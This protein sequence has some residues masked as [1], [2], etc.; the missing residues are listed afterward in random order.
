MFV[1]KNAWRAITR[2][3]ARNVTF[4]IVCMAVT[5]STVVGLTVLQADEDTRTTIY[6]SQSAEAVISPR[7]GGKGQGKTA[8]PLGWEEY[9]KYAQFLQANSLQ[10]GVYYYESAPARFL[11]LKPA[12]TKA[13][14]QLVGLSDA[15]V[16]AKGPYGKIKRTQGKDPDY[17]GTSGDSAMISQSMAKANKLKPG[18]TIRLVDPKDASRTID[19][20]VSGVYEAKGSD[21]AANAV[22]TSFTTFAQHGFDRTTQP[23]DKGHEL[24]VVFQLQ[25]PA[26]LKQFTDAL[27]KAGLSEKQYKVTSPSLQAYQRSVQPLHDQAGKIKGLLIAI[28]VFG[29]I[30]ALVWL[31]FALMARGNE[32]G[33]AITIGVTKARIGWRLALE[34]LM[35]TLPGL[36]LGLVAGWFLCPPAIRSLISLPG[37]QQT[38]GGA[39]LW[40]AGG[41]GLLVCL[42]LAVAAWLHAGL[43]RTSRLYE[44]GAPKA[45]TDKN[46][47]AADADA[48]EN[49]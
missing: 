28:L 24:K 21:V 36:I 25:N 23:G 14:M 30:L 41:T 35:I 11:D 34:T 27:H 15:S 39:I 1:L 38:A 7:T 8:K 9:S 19:V 12:D 33:M 2:N 46:A 16:T 3:K 37:I 32:L 5:A 48:K 6:D 40:R 45:S 20:K 4:L 44:T 49:A 17:A 26:A 31:A 43:Y 42:A 47:A 29:A 18:S 22:Y 10:F 13:D